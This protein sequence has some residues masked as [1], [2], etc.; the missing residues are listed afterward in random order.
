MIHRRDPYVVF[1]EWKSCKVHKPLAQLSA[2]ELTSSGSQSGGGQGLQL[3]HLT[4]EN[5]CQTAEEDL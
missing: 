3:Q 5:P 4:T 1:I 2:V